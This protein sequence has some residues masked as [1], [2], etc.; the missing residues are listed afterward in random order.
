MTVPLGQSCGPV[1]LWHA[2]SHTLRQTTQRS[3]THASY[4]QKHNF[5]AIG[6]RLGVPE[7]R[8]RA[9]SRSHT[10]TDGAAPADTRRRPEGVP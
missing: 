8:S 3:D 6:P 9:R 4:T 7:D 1:R 10:R 2:A 5:F